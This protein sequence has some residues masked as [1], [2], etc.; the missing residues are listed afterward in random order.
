MTSAPYLIGPNQKFTGEYTTQ[1]HGGLTY[2]YDATWTRSGTRIIWSAT[3][4]R[5]GEH[6]G[7]PSG[8]I[9]SAIELEPVAAVTALVEYSIENLFQVDN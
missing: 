8:T 7:Q 1:R 6:K 2:S 5:N 4:S 3:V 9:Q